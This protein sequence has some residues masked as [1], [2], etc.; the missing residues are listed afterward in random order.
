MNPLLRIYRK[1]FFDKFKDLNLLQ[2]VSENRII[3]NSSKSAVVTLTNVWEY[4]Q[5]WLPDEDI[6]TATNNTKAMT[7][8]LFLSPNKRQAKML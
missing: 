3:T 6:K 4:E 8:P 7:T 2:K 1:I 5:D